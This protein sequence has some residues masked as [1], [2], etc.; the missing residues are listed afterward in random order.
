MV[1]ILSSVLSANLIAVEVLLEESTQVVNSATN[2]NADSLVESLT[3]E[4]STVE[5]AA[6][7][8]LLLT[9]NLDKEIES[10]DTQTKA[11][12]EMEM[13]IELPQDDKY[14]WLQLVSGEWLKG[15]LISL[16]SFSVEFKSKKLNLLTIKWADI[17]QLR[18]ARSMSIRVEIGG[19]QSIITVIGKLQLLD[20]SVR[21]VDGTKVF[22]YQRYQ[23]ISIAK[24]TSHESDY[25]TG[26]IS[27][28][29]NV[30]K[31]NSDITDSNITASA[32]R[33]TAKSRLL[34]GYV[35]NF[36]KAQG[37][38]T[39]NNHRLNSYYDSFLNR[40]FFWRVYSVEY[41][42]DTFKNIDTQVSLGSSFGYDLIRTSKT[43]WEISGGLGALYKRFVSVGPGE[44][45]DNVS[46][47]LEFGTKY[48]T[49]LTTTMKYLFDFSFQLV[50][51]S[52]GTYIHHLITTLSSGITGRMS[53]DV[54]F[55]WD[56]IADPQP[57][58]NLTV[59]EKDDIQLIVA[60]SYKF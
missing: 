45:I 30:K 46:T 42:R 48:N 25:W 60:V 59:P 19:E 6:T 38:E 34:L 58:A 21:I 36:S 10:E 2:N 14:D 54:S 18:S 50:D 51:E 16:Y 4:V 17:K 7:A 56:R 3:G 37:V 20:D 15:E 1:F 40:K 47:F 13:R 35:G 55:V 49:K 12:K 44:E 11:K 52:S 27:F 28:G 53:L 5:L 31:G 33:R 57:V 32:Q 29:A 9:E 23:I 26:R 43:E 8:P 22:S 24:S 39:S 41:H